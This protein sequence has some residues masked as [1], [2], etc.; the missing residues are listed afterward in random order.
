MEAASAAAF[1]AFTD[2]ES[3][4]WSIWEG[5]IIRGCEVD[6]TRAITMTFNLEENETD[7]RRKLNA[8]LDVAV[9]SRICLARG[10]RWLKCAALKLVSSFLG[11]N[12]GDIV[13]YTYIFLKRQLSLE[14]A[15]L[16]LQPSLCELNILCGGRWLANAKTHKYDWHTYIQQARNWRKPVWSRKVNV[17]L[18]WSSDVDL[19]WW[20]K[21]LHGY[22]FNLH[23]VSQIPRPCSK[24]QPLTPC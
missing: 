11:I 18:L 12:G 14:L 21:Y 8:K 22:F 20:L 6:H 24:Q 16:S 10:H 3:V 17:N 23:S 9:T 5:E 13:I 2:L 1:A 19:W 4:D 15:R 7:G